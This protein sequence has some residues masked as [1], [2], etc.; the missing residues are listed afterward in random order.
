MRVFYFIIIPLLSIIDALLISKPNFLGKLGLWIFKYS[1]LRTFPRA[2]VTVS[3]VVGGA[4]LLSE[5]ITGLGKR[6][7][8]KIVYFLLLLVFLAFSGG[9]LFKIVLDFSKGIY[10]H[11]GSYFKYGVMLL[12]SILIFIFV[13]SL[14]RLSSKKL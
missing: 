3:I 1:Y 7:S 12:P 13:T 14:I 2:L 9:V 10:S 11:T 8:K 6:N 4:L 5:L